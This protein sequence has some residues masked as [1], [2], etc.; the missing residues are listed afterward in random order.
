VKLLPRSRVDLEKW[1]LALMDSLQAILLLVTGT[2]VVLS[3]ASI[4]W[5]LRREADG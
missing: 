5:P 3:F 1:G 4:P 2:I